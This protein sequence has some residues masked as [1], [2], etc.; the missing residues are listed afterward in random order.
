MYIYIRTYILLYLCVSACV[1][2]HM[3]V[4]LNVYLSHW[5]PHILTLHVSGTNATFTAI[6]CSLVEHT[7][8][9]V[10]VL[11]LCH[12]TRSYTHHT[13]HVSVCITV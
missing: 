8:Y 11:K 3:D 10:F 7:A 2:V 6:Y 9:N 5:L 4:H 13:I 12:V 1:R